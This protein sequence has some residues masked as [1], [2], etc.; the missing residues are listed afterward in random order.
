MLYKNYINRSHEGT[1]ETAEDAFK[2][3]LQTLEKAIRIESVMQVSITK[4]PSKKSAQSI[5]GFQI[6][7]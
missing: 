3:A 4:I 2:S 7:Y 5:S 6:T 1:F